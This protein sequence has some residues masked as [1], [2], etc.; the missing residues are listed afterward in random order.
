MKLFYIVWYIFAGSVAIINVWIGVHGWHW[1]NL[2][3]GVALF[4]VLS[5]YIIRYART[6]R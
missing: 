5:R 6:S 3:A 4:L 1:F 2:A